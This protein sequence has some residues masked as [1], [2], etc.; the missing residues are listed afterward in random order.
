MI[1]FNDY[2]VI[3]PI[4]E[5]WKLE[6]EKE[7]FNSRSAM[8]KEFLDTRVHLEEAEIH[9]PLAKKIACAKKEHDKDRKEKHHDKSELCNKRH[10]GQGKCHTGKRKKKYCDYHGL[11]HHDTKECNYYQACRKH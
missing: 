1:K 2:L 5:E 4:L 6:F 11:F 3:F 9:K 8:P 10:H 7:G